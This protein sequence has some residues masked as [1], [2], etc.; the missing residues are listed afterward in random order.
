MFVFERVGLKYSAIWLLEGMDV[1]VVDEESYSDVLVPVL[2]SLQEVSDPLLVAF[3]T[4]LGG[5]M[6]R[7]ATRRISL[8]AT[9]GGRKP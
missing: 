7:F 9:E 2:V 5:V 1:V 4:S 6:S 8:F 3:D